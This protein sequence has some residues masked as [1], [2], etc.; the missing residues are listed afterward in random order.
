ML[1]RNRDGLRRKW[2]ICPI[3]L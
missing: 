2:P 1:T 3:P